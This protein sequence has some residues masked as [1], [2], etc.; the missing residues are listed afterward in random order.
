[1]LRLGGPPLHKDVALG[2]VPRPLTIGRGPRC[3][4]PGLGRALLLAAG[5]PLALRPSFEHRRLESEDPSAPCNVPG[6]ASDGSAKKEKRGAEAP[7]PP[8][9]KEEKEGQRSCCGML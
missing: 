9:P 3:M 5:V 6:S 1:M 4:P 7:D 8:P 2:R